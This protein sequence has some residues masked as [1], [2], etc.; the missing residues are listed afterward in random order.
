MVLSIKNFKNSLEAQKN[1]RKSIVVGVINMSQSKKNKVL[2]SSDDFYRV[3]ITDTQPYHMPIIFNNYG[4][5]NAI[6]KSKNQLIFMIFL[7]KTWDY[8]M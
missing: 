2:L 5:Y 3:L 8:L 7:L 6:D 1:L 4:F